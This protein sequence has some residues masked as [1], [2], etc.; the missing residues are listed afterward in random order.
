MSDQL[1]NTIEEIEKFNEWVRIEKE[2]LQRR[3]IMEYF[4]L[5]ILLD[6]NKDTS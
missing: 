1:K 3:A 4:L 6:D 2:A 5:P